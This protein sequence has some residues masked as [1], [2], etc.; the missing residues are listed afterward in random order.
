M[1]FSFFSVAQADS[2]RFSSLP[3]LRCSC[4]V[5]LLFGGCCSC[6]AS[7]LALRNPTPS[8]SHLLGLG[9]HQPRLLPSHGMGPLCT[10]PLPHAAPIITWHVPTVSTHVAIGAPPTAAPT[11]TW[12]ADP[13]TM[14]LA[15]AC[16]SQPPDLL[17]PLLAAPQ[18]TRVWR[19]P[20][21]CRS[22]AL[23]RSC[24]ASS[25]QVRRGSHK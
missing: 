11:I 22:R 14:P 9:P 7:K 4:W 24:S 13:F 25:A 10:L 12:L 19:Q 16:P 17:C 15:W 23:Q 5:H 21:C 8:P 6:G 2:G 1:F 3:V 18:T 20:S